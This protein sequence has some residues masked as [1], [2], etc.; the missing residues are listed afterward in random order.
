MSNSLPTFCA[1]LFAGAILAGAFAAA[2]QM[3]VPV[4]TARLAGVAPGGH[5]TFICTDRDGTWR[6]GVNAQTM[7][8]SITTG[9]VTYITGTV[10]C[11]S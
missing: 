5:S 10:S 4:V 8:T 11:P 7:Q 9:G 2:A 6:R 1:G 3:I